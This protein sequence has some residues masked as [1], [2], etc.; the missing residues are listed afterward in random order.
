MT[1]PGLGVTKVG[2]DEANIYFVYVM[3][4]VDTVEGLGGLVEV[5]KDLGIEHWG[6][7]TVDMED[8]SLGIRCYAHNQEQWV[9]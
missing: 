8:Y 4:A 1:K 5:Y 9:G 6:G 3:E 2:M 7:V